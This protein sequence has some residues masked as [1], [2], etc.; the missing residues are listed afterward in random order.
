MYTIIK[1]LYCNVKSCV[2]YNC[3][4][5]EFFNV[6]KGLMQ[7]EGLSPFLFSLYINDFENYMLYNNCESVELRD[8]SLF[9]IMYAD[10]TVL[11]SESISGLQNLL[12]NVHLYCNEWDI[13]VNV[14]KTKIVVFR[15]GGR[16]SKKA[17]WYY[18]SNEIEVVDCFNYLGISLLYNGKFTRTQKVL[19]L[20]GR[21]CMYSILNTCNAEFLNVETRLQVFDTYVSSVLN[22]GCEVWGFNDAKDI[23]KIHMDFCKRILKVRKCTPNYMIYSELGRFPLILTRKFRIIKYWIKLLNCDNIILKSL[24]DDML[25]RIDSVSWLSRVR[26]LLMSLGFGYVWFNQYVANPEIFLAQVKSVLYDQFIQEM[27]GYFN[28]SSKCFLYSY[29][30]ETHF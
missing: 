10:D 28:S 1:S 13:K 20:Q 22:Y 11:F 24:Y 26:N 16:I 27:N 15:N 18:N 4:I 25:S 6:P 2:R 21:K 3:E 12:D 8:L 5:S 9:L 17:V 29:L 23:E 19:S 30:Y 14:N 7:G